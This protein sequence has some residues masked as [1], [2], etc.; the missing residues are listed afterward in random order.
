MET[1]G[2]PAVAVKKTTL[3]PKAIISQ[4][5]GTNAIYEVEEVQEP[6]ENGCPGLAI[7]QKRPCLYRCI[8]QLPEIS[9]MSGT[10]KKKKEA[11]QSAAEMAIK[12]VLSIS[13]SI[14]FPPLSL[15]FDWLAS[16]I[17][18]HCLS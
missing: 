10:F 15:L 8:L 18:I 1:G 16:C 4:K 7:S 12:E 9:V 2:S 3:S 6:A 13:L 17:F 5:F 11:E 14:I